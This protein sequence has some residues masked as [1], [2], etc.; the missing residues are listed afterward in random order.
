MQRHSPLYLLT[1]ILAFCSIVYELIL[2]QALAAFLENTILR[3][4]VTIGLYMF[5]M[6]VGSFFAEGKLVKDPPLVLVRVE[7][8]LTLLGGFSLIFLHFLEAAGASRL[9]FNLFAY[10]LIILIG[11]FTGAE[12]PLLM[13]ITKDQ[14]KSV[15]NSQGGKEKVILAF[16]YAGAFT[17]TFIF[18]FIFYPIFGL[19]PA[20]LVTGFLN[21]W[22]GMLLFRERAHVGKER[23]KAFS[24]A[25]S[26]QGVLWVLMSL[27]LFFSQKISYYFLSLYLS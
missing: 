26:L 18:A 16:N 24:W 17:G 27:C 8:V 23:Q 3:Y 9:V 5:S 4:S 6:G 12:M 20:C 1:F 7:I 15:T 2:A 25:I 22:C 11:I 10:G 21:A 19:I 13:E 14:D